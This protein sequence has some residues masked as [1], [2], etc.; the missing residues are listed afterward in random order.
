MEQLKLFEEVWYANNKDQSK[1]RRNDRVEGRRVLWERVSSTN[2]RS[3][4]GSGSDI[5]R[6]A[7]GRGGD[8]PYII[9]KVEGDIL[10]VVLEDCPECPFKQCKNCEKGHCG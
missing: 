7:S 6:E 10:R 2:G 8:C 1:Q 9:I 3:G 4:K 5:G